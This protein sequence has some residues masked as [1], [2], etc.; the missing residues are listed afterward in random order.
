[1]NEQPDPAKT[2]HTKNSGEVNTMVEAFQKTLGSRDIFFQ[3][4]DIFP[5]AIEIFAPDGTS[6]FINRAACEDANI[7][8]PKEVIGHYNVLNDPVILDV[9]AQ[10]PFIE[11]AF[12]G[13]TITVSNV[14]VP[15]EDTGARYTK[16]DENYNEVKYQSITGFPIRDEDQQITYIVMI[17]ITTNTF[18]GKREIVN[19]QEYINNTWKEEFDLEKT[20]KTVNLSVY[21]FSRLF[22]QETGITPLTYYRR[23]KVSKLKEKLRDQNVTIEQAFIECGVDYNGNYLHYFKEITG[24]TPSQFR[25]S[26]SVK[27]S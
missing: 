2:E 26:T 5:Y 11:Q 16:A 20:A 8:D 19:A 10:R 12:K 22:K 17:F 15:Y 6:V 27:L 1:M 18:K 23:L 13:E 14:R 21:H 4:L 9:L 25:K 7:A 3:F 24:Q